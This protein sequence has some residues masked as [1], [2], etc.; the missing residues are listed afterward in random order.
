M[1]SPRRRLQQ[2]VSTKEILSSEVP[3]EHFKCGSS[4]AKTYYF[5]VQWKSSLI[6]MQRRDEAL[7]ATRDAIKAQEDKKRA[8]DQKQEE[9]AHR[10]VEKAAEL[11]ESMTEQ[12]AARDSKLSTRKQRLD[13]AACRK[14]CGEHY[15][16][17]ALARASFSYW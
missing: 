7:Q 17:A 13:E 3:V 14:A 16:D 4:K 12:I 9:A 5:A 1:P 6:G 2:A 8:F 10:A 11:A 15:D